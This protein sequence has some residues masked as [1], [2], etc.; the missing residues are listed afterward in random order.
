MRIDEIGATRVWVKGDASA[1]LFHPDCYASVL[2]AW[3]GNERRFTGRDLYGDLL[4]VKVADIV[5]VNLATPEVLAIARA[6]E[7]EQKQREALS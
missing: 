4:T 3:D 7:E 5:A 6:D 1:F 2:A